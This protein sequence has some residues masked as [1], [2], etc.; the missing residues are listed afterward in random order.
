LTRSASLALSFLAGYCN[1]VLEIVGPRYMASVYG[2][3]TVV[4]SAAITATLV[5]LSLGYWLGAILPERRLPFSLA[6]TLAASGIL[7]YF[8]GHVVAASARW[9]VT[10]GPGSIVATAFAS[11]LFPSVAFGMIPQM[12]IRMRCLATGTIGSTVGE[13][14]AVGTLGAVAGALS[15]TFFLI[16]WLGLSTTLLGLASALIFSSALSMKSILGL[17]AGAPL[18]LL[19]APNLQWTLGRN[20]LAQVDSEYQTIRVLEDT[21]GRWRYMYLGPQ[22][23]SEYD[24]ITRRPGARYALALVRSLGELDGTRALL[25]GG[26]GNSI[27]HYLES[28]NV[29]TVTV[30][31]DARV[32]ELTEQF[33][34]G[35]RG[36]T[37]VADGRRFL[38]DYEGEPFDYVLLDAFGGPGFIPYHLATVEFYELTRRVLAPNGIVVQNTH[39]SLSGSSAAAFRAYA[40]TIREVFPF[41]SCLP[42]RPEADKEA[43]Q[44]ILVYASMDVLQVEGLMPAP[45]DGRVITDDRNPSDVLALQA[46]LATWDGPS[47]LAR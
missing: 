11:L 33:F 5:G 2:S 30:E 43:V 38:R 47:L 6:T 44:N 32:V 26:A 23:D 31:V 16:P 13:V 10:S 4:W 29:E 21:N 9:L 41:V 35:S 7:S 25:I 3:T 15:A 14:C 28:E 20:L 39:G 18:L 24:V 22:C 36:R 12:L 19:P 34:G 8:A 46:H 40:T 45:A 27:A 17:A 42:V 37:V 1:L